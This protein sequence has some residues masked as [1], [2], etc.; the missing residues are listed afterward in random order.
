[1]F[2]NYHNLFVQRSRILTIYFYTEVPIEFSSLQKKFFDCKS[3]LNTRCRPCRTTPHEPV[4]DRAPLSVRQ[5]SSRSSRWSSRYLRPTR[6][7]CRSQVGAGVSQRAGAGGFQR[8]CATR[9]RTSHQ[10]VSRLPHRPSSIRATSAQSAALIPM[11]LQKQ[12]RRWRVLQSRQSLRI[13]S[14]TTGSTRSQRCTSTTMAWKTPR[15]RD[16]TLR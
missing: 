14:A 11:L 1:M 5:G 2:Y 7:S 3:V 4:Y 13:R 10:S 16:S 12:R 8:D 15:N 9:A 6:T